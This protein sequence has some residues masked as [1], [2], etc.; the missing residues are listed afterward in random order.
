MRKQFLFITGIALMFFC[1]GSGCNKTT[2]NTAGN[3]LGNKP[4]ETQNTSLP[5]V[6][7]EQKSGGFTVTAEPKENGTLDVKFNVPE[8][9]SKDA[10]AYRLLLSKEANPSWPTKGY[11]YELGKTHTAK[12]WSGL[13]IGSRNLRVCVVKNDECVAYSNNAEVDIK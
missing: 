9:L 12:L 5:A 7:Q 10:E 8:D 6:I 1:I 3:L 4:A 13:P 11:W 2:T